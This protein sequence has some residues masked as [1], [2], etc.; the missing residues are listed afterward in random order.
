MKVL[1]AVL[2]LVT[3]LSSPAITMIS[4]SGVAHERNRVKGK[5]VRVD[6]HSI[7]VHWFPESSGRVGA[8]QISY[9]QKFQLTP[10]TIY[11]NWTWSSISKGVTMRL[12]GHGN[13]VDRVQL[14]WEVN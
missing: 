5:V 4:A 14:A 3:V 7:T 11:E 10:Q 12:Y 6:Q 13:I 8:H 2:L 1:V 9:E